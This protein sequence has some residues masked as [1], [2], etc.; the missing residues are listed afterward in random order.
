MIQT[1]SPSY[2]F[3]AMMDKC[4]DELEKKGM[5]GINYLWTK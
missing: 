1:S 2:I 5:G 4:R 3:M